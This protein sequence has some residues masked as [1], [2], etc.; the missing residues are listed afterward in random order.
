M[1]NGNHAAPPTSGRNSLST[2]IGKERKDAQGGQISSEVQ[3]QMQGLRKWQ[4]R[5]TSSSYGLRFGITSLDRVSE[6]LHMPASAKESAI[7]IYR[8]ALDKGL[9]KHHS[10][11]SLS[12]ASAYVAC[13]LAGVPRTL[14]DFAHISRLPQRDLGRAYADI[15]TTLELQ[16]PIEDPA[17]YVSKI[18]TA[19]GAPIQVQQKALKIIAEARKKHLTA[20]KL[21]K[22]VAAAALYLASIQNDNPLPQKRLTAAAN[23]SDVALR[24]TFH[25]LR[26]V[27]AEK[28]PA[29]QAASNSKP[30]RR[31][32][33][34]LKSVAT[35]IGL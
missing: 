4:Q 27:L 22:V 25:K 20:G 17:R 9:Q 1:T 10:I 18:A 8:R 33:G 35:S 30:Q 26:D 23:I 2:T 6:T 24:Y 34:L 5:F 11:A 19:A 12:T 15:K 3:T 14:K 31:N 16:V 32:R 29:P 13:R 21:P 7:V 28:P